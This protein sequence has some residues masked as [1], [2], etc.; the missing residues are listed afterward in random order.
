MPIKKG[1]RHKT[2][3]GKT[4]NIP[5]SKSKNKKKLNKLASIYVG[6][7]TS[8]RRRKDTKVNKSYCARVAHSKSGI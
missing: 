8:K 3:K 2:K 4:F 5:K 6:C 7:R 1:Y